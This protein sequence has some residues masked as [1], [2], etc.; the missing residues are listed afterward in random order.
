MIRPVIQRLCIAAFAAFASSLILAVDAR[1]E[2]RKLTFLHIND[3]YEFLPGDNRGGLAEL[4][5]LIKEE[6]RRS[7]D[8]LVTF[9]G[10]LLSPSVASSVTQG[11]HMID[12]FNRMEIS[13]ATLGNHEFDFGAETLRQRMKESAFPWVVSNALEQDG[14][15]FGGAQELRVIE[16]GGVKVGYFGI[17][18]SETAHMSAGAKRV[19]FKPEIETAR[20]SVAALKAM[21]ADVIVAL[22]HLDLDEDR[23]LLREVGGINLVLGG[24]D[25]NAV[26]LEEDGVLIIKAGENAT[27]LAIVDLSV[28]TL[29]DRDGRVSVK[30]RSDSWGF[31]PTKSASSDGEVL[32]LTQ[33]YD[34]ELSGALDKPITKLG[35][36]LDSREEFVRSRETA[37]GNL[38]ADALKSSFGAD[39]ALING[40]S[41]RGNRQYE[42]GAA[43]TRADVLREFPFRNSAVLIEIRGSDLLAALEAG[44]SKAPAKAGRFPQVAG[45][46]F[47]FNPSAE[48]GKRVRKVFVAGKPLSA[49][50]TYRLATNSYLADGGDGYEALKKGRMLIDR[51]SAP[52]LTTL[53]IDAL[54]TMDTVQATVE[55]RIL[56]TN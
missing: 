23:K 48:P 33:K 47:S 3:I 53:V 16:V 35:V 9:A 49:T 18:T 56:E 27:H 5:T 20:K 42:A 46:K 4:K 40:G 54:T 21:G 7:P 32:A 29:K 8:A 13:A 38:V 52:I 10:D 37:I 28:E 41:L 34:S 17:L 55:G 14:S 24:H 26:A 30:V 15:P 31:R 50:A 44:V 12:F 39:A 1:A 19:V 36:K 6:R 51:L 43:F 25:H 45:I 2:S 22:T 11:S